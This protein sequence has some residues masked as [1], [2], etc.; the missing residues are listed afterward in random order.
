M[1]RIKTPYGD[2]ELKA[3]SYPNKRLA[4]LLYM[5]DGELF[6]D[7][8]I[9][10]PYI[11]IQNDEGFINSNIEMINTDEFNITKLLTDLGIIKASYGYTQYNFGSYDYVKFDLDVL[12]NYDKR[13]ITKYLKQI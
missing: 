9:N 13:G 7:L 10:L 12:K 11:T 8:T 5:E 2:L 4:L 6:D 1:E 3:F